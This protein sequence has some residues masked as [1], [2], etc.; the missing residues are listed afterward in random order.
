[1]QTSIKK[2]ILNQIKIISP[3]LVC[4]LLFFIP[5]LLGLENLYHDDIA[6]E[7][8][9]RQ[10]AMARIFQSGEYPL[11]DKLRFYGAIPF[12]MDNETNVYNFFLIPFYYLADL[13]SHDKAFAYLYTIPYVLSSLISGIFSFYL[14]YHGFKL[15]K[16][17]SYLC[18]LM[19]IGS[20]FF[21]FDGLL[22]QSNGFFISSI[23][24]LLLF[25]TSYRNKNIS[26]QL[27]FFYILSACFSIFSGTLNLQIRFFLFYFIFLLF[28]HK[29]FSKENIK[30]FLYDWFII[31]LLTSPYWLSLFKGIL[32]MGADSWGQTPTEKFAYPFK[33]LIT[34][35]YPNY[36]DIISLNSSEIVPKIAYFLGNTSG[37]YLL[38]GGTIAS[39]LIFHFI[40]QKFKQKKNH[41]LKLFFIIFIFFIFSFN[42]GSLSFLNPTSSLPFP[43][44]NRFIWFINYAIVLSMAY[45][46]FTHYHA[47]LLYFHSIICLTLFTSIAST[48]HNPLDPIF[49]TSLICYLLFFIGIHIFKNFKNIIFFLVFI[50][51]IIPSYFVHYKI[52]SLRLKNEDKLDIQLHGM[53]YNRPSSHPL[54]SI[55]NTLKTSF[56]SNTSMINN[57]SWQFNQFSING[58]D[59]KPLNPRYTKIFR[60]YLSNI[61]WDSHFSYIP[62]NLLRNLSVHE[63][64]GHASEIRIDEEYLLIKNGPSLMRKMI[65][66]LENSNSSD[67]IFSP[68]TVIKTDQEKQQNHITWNDT[69]QISM[70]NFNHINPFDSKISKLERKHNSIKFQIIQSSDTVYI[71]NQIFDSNW[72][73]SDKDIEFF[74]INYLQQGIKIYGSGKKEII[75]YYWPKEWSIGFIFALLGLFLLAINCSLFK[76][77]MRSFINKLFNRNII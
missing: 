51:T 28:C 36:F 10:M 7:F 75:L 19:F 29:K 59:A 52:S 46:Y 62:L 53:R 61:P 9:P 1:M 14:A 4:G 70:A 13:T 44:Y 63:Y 35:F 76:A 21:L 17:A 45:H 32:W 42:L 68:H 20:Y 39:F 3:I 26:I 69:R 65:F 5:G 31:I 8:F 49:Y 72:T 12:H 41:D 22:Y 66:P 64:I 48:S 23:P 74:P 11:W 43:Y 58:F 47:K 73:S 54:F 71:L 2:N 16:M 27:R 67:F 50:E 30:K 55:G 18:S 25:S 6:K 56:I 40:F 34:F 37:D 15:S 33:F 57:F 77:V 60:P 24:A 38:P